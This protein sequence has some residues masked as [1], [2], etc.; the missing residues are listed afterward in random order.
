MRKKCDHKQDIKASH[1]RVVHQAYTERQYTARSPRL[2]VRC[3]PNSHIFFLTVRL[4]S[5]ISLAVRK[6][7]EKCFS[8]V[9]VC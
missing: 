6:A 7:G 3:R 5:D 8:V 4:F 1:D 2:E 9:F